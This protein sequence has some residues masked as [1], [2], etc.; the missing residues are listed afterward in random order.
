L[1]ATTNLVQYH[2]NFTAAKEIC[3]FAFYVEENFAKNVKICELIN[4]DKH[5]V[6]SVI[7]KNNHNYFANTNAGSF[8]VLNV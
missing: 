8:I 4:W 7:V 2:P 3:Q 6:I 1:N 5:H